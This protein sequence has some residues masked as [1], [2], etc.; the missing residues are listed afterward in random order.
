MS[1]KRYYPHGRIAPDDD[2]ASMMEIGIDEKHEVIIMQ[3]EEP[4]VWIGLE[5]KVAINIAESL[6]KKARSISK[7]PLVLNI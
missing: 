3:F 4:T 6:I 7:E 2:G 1:K 5:P